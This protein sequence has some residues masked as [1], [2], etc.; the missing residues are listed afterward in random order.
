MTGKPHRTIGYLRVSTGTQDLEKNRAEILAFQSRK[1]D[2]EAR[3]Q[4][5]KA[6]KSYGGFGTFMPLGPSWGRVVLSSENSSKRFDLL[7]PPSVFTREQDMRPPK[8]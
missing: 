6:V 2:E 5:T 1:L 3:Y 4:E 7:F 8:R